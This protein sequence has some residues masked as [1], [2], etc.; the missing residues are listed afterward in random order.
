MNGAAERSTLMARGERRPFGR[1][2]YAAMP[3]EVAVM[4]QAYSRGRGEQ[5]WAA[6]GGFCGPIADGE[7]GGRHVAETQRC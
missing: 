6:A 3:R 2:G 4:P 5:F 7:A 1:G